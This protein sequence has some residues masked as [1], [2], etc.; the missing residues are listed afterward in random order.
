M[1]SP[2]HPRAI[3]SRT[4]AEPLYI[5]YYSGH[6]GKFGHEF[7]EFDLRVHPDGKS[8]FL[9]YANNS[10]YKNDTM[11]RKNVTVSP[12]VINEFRKIIED[13][14]IVKEDDSQWPEK[15]RDGKQELEIKIGNYHIC[16]ETAKIGALSDIQNSEDSDGL[17][18]FYYLVNDLK[19][20]VFSL[21]SLHFKVKPI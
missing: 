4:F 10:N 13:C 6:Q 17:R 14:E 12:A 15:N 2:N 20:F 3:S 16:F 8:G 19:A 5:R 21:I 9:R 7:L 1:T 11:I 18:V